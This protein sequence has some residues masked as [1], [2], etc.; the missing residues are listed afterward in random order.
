M[1]CRD[2]GLP[3]DTRSIVGTSGNAFERQPAREG[4]T[5]TLANNSKNSA[6][7]S[8]EL[9]LDIPGSTKQPESEM[10]QEPQNSSIPV[11]RFQSGGGLLNHTGGTCSHGGMNDY[12]RF[13]FSELHLGKFAHSMEFQSWYVNF[14]T[15]V[16]SQNSRPHLTV[17]L[18]KV[19]ERAKSIG[20]LMTSRSIVGRNDFPD[21]DMLDAMFASALK[22]HLN[23]HILSR[24]KVSIE[25]QHAQK[26]D[27]F[28]RGR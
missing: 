6:S 20:D 26:Y 4:R 7:S 1:P 25:E 12:T 10:R 24:N 22:R 9:R 17:H 23:K 27:R 16:C 13:P 3:H 21:Y 19:V 8:Q 18:I 15:K 28:L 14:K 5:S 11:P 2:F